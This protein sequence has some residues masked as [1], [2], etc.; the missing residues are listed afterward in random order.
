MD[1]CRLE[2]KYLLSIRFA[3]AMYF[4]YEPPSASDP[5]SQTDL[6]CRFALGINITGI[7]TL[8][9]VGLNHLRRTALIPVLALRVFRDSI[10]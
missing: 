8:I 2:G 5:C 9:K 1:A 3:G 7:I 4:L 6:V 10:I